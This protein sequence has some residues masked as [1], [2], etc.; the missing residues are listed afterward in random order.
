M[1]RKREADGGKFAQPDWWPDWM[2]DPDLFRAALEDAG[3]AAALSR[4]SGVPRTTV[5]TFWMFGFQRR[6]V[7][8][9]ECEMLWPKPG[10]LP[11]TSQLAAIVVLQF[12]WGAGRRPTRFDPKGI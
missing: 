3:S 10:P 5:R 1:G 12:R 6:G 4:A 7:R 8:R 9:W 11:Q 2:H